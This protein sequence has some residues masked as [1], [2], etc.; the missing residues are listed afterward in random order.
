M[1]G[2][3]AGTLQYRKV[4]KVKTSMLTTGSTRASADRASELVCGYLLNRSKARAEYSAAQKVH[5]DV[6]SNSLKL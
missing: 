1:S 2:C 6:L 4:F 3:D 5:C